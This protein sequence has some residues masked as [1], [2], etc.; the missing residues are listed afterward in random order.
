MASPSVAAVG[1]VNEVTTR[2]G[3]GEAAACAIVTVCPP[4][5]KVPVRSVVFVFRATE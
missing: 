3:D 1:A 2:S 4:M 5:V